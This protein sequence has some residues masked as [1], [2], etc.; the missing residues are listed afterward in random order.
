MTK[1]IALLTILILSLVLLPGCPGAGSA[2]VGTWILTTNSFDYGLELHADGT[3]TSFMI[4]FV[5]C[6]TLTWEVRGTE[7]IMRVVNSNDSYIFV[8][9]IESET[10]MSGG[11]IIWEGMSEGESALWT[12]VKQ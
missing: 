7:F 11:W 9:R 12:A 6:C 5:Y 8:G 2:L 1:R 3:A 4:D 10:S